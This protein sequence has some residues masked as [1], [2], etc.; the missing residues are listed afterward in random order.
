MCR[1]IFLLWLAATLWGAI[2]CL[3]QASDEYSKRYAYLTEMRHDVKDLPAFAGQ[4]DRY[5][6][7]LVDARH[8]DYSSFEKFFLTM[9][10]GAVFS[11]EPTIGHAWVIIGE[12]RGEKTWLFEGGHTG[13]FG[14]HVPRYFDE[15]LHR[16]YT[17][18]DP[19]PAKYFFFPLPDGQLQIGSGGHIP[20]FAVAIPISKE[21]LLRIQRLFEPD[22][23]DFSQWSIQGPQC[24]RFVRTCLAVAGVDVSCIEK[25]PLPQ[26]VQ[27]RGEKRTL[28]RESTYSILSVETP[29]LLEKRLWELARAGRALV[30]TQWYK[31][32]YRRQAR[33][34]VACSSPSLLPSFFHTI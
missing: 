28:W 21:Q 24:V 6:V 19:N 25:I 11:R 17:A 7:I 27:Y 33:E 29:D 31:S 2:S 16:A 4:L 30:A 34:Q 5:L 8:L 14:G 20:T 32:V 9:N 26:S 10:S 23:Y 15:V 12:R 18:E 1:S 22:G 13:E 3:P